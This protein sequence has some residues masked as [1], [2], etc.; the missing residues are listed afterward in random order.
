MGAAGGEILSQQQVA[1]AEPKSG[2]QQQNRGQ[3]HRQPRSG[4]EGER[5]AAR[6]ENRQNGQE[7]EVVARREPQSQA[8]ARRRDRQP[9]P[10]LAPPWA[11]IAEEVV[12][13][14]QRDQSVEAEPVRGAHETVPERIGLRAVAGVDQTPAPH[15]ANVAAQRTQRGQPSQTRR[16]DQSESRQRPRPLRRAHNRHTA[17]NQRAFHVEEKGGAR[18]RARQ[19]RQ[20]GGSR[21]HSGQM[22]HEHGQI[23]G[24]GNH[25]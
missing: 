13:G 25:R 19:Q 24:Y 2:N 14:A 6:A 17:R 20:A 5:E 7:L 15:L 18:Q 12:K 22:R 3:G 9:D 11:A 1:G 16:Q 4:L 10:R 23:D 21:G 8:H